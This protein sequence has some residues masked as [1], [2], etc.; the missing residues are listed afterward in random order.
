MIEHRGR[1]TKNELAFIEFLDECF[2]KLF[3]VDGTVEKADEHIRYDIYVGNS[4]N[5][6][7]FALQFCVRDNEDLETGLFL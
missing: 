6:E 4:D 7:F 1:F 3:F 5:R 2:S